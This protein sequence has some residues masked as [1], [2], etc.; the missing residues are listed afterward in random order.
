[1]NT[2]TMNGSN[3][4]LH[5]NSTSVFS[6]F[7]STLKSKVSPTSDSIS[8]T[9]ESIP[10]YVGFI[11]CVIAVLFFGSN[12]IPVKQY[13]TGDGEGYPYCTFRKSLIFNSFGNL[14]PITFISCKN[15]FLL[16]MVTVHS[17]IS[18]WS[19]CQCHQIL[20]YLSSIG[21]DWR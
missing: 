21:Y 9:P 4:S 12:Y 17:H 16:S 14:K 10:P 1:M 15:R 18:S 6:T 19:D 5:A 2:R 7:S 20:P 3:F 8:D 13:K 11:C